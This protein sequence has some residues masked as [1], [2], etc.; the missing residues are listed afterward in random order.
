M[1]NM[2]N[3]I[4]DSKGEKKYVNVFKTRDPRIVQS[5]KSKSMQDSVL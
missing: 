4:C 2:K 5:F 3:N 1:K